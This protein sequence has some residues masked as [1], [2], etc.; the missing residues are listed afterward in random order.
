M[1]TFH[2]RRFRHSTT[3]SVDK[4]QQT[5]NYFSVKTGVGI[6]SRGFVTLL[7][8]PFIDTKVQVNIYVLQGKLRL[9]LFFLTCSAYIVHSKHYKKLINRV[10]PKINH[11][12]R[13]ARIVLEKNKFSK[14]VTSYR[15]WTLDP[16]TV[17][18]AHFMCLQWHAL[19]TVLISIALR[20]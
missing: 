6:F 19:P 15:D 17:H 14:K 18:S 13:S 5:I 12:V 2:R 10:F 11:S 1:T 3:F 8:S 7:T 16:R 4:G 9:V 20:T